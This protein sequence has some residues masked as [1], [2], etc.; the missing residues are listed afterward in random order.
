MSNKFA[1]PVVGE[2]HAT[3]DA[4]LEAVGGDIAE[5]MQQV[6]ARQ[7]RSHHRIIR[8]PFRNCTESA[9]AREAAVASGMKSESHVPPA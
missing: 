5:L 8:Q 1:D 2:I 4:M 3:R 7:Q 9:D 6:A